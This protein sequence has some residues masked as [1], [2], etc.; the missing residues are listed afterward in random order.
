MEL[1]NNEAITSMALVQFTGAHDT[2]T[3]LAVGTAERMTYFP[4]DCTAG[5]IRIYRIQ[6]QGKVLELMHKT[7]L[8]GIPGALVGFKGRLLAGVGPVLR[9][10]DLGKK[11]L[12]RKC[13]YRQL[14]HHVVTLQTMGSRIFVGDVQ[15]SVHFFRYNKTDN[16]LYCFADDIN[17][18]YVTTILPLDY[19]TVALADKFGN[20]SVL[21][22]PPDVSAQVEDDPTGG[23]LAAQ[24]GKAGGA[25]NKLTNLIQFH[26]GDTVT[27]LALTAMQAG[28]TEVV[29]YGSIMGGIGAF[30]PLAS[31]QDKDFFLH[32]EMHMRQEAAPLAG[33]DHL[34]Y[35]SA[36]FP[37]REVVD[38]DL[39]TMFTT[40]PAARQRQVASELDR[41]TGE[42]LKKLEDTVSKIL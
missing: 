12:L 33:R 34:A 29:L 3:L 19:D 17:P 22:L 6:D 38:G 31:K 37:V 4:S 41:T 16:K 24:M 39:C 30:F 21:R 35:R 1:D 13:E 8:D 23:K 11:K 28:G 18:R 26:V 36:Y 27:A 7:Q 10:L 20:F 42:V 5:Y 40:L 9:L 25:P 32:L 15:E 14:P 2:S